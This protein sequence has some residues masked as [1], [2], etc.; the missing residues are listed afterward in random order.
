[1]PQMSPS[2]WLILFLFFIKSFYMILSTIYFKWSP[3]NNYTNKLIYKLKN[4]NFNDK[5]F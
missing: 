3:F 2:W 1:M 5:N 4:F